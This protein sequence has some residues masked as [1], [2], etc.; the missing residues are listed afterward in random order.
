M[1][2][3]DKN[4]ELD[5]SF[6]YLLTSNLDFES[7]TSGSAQPQITVTNL[8]GTEFIIPEKKVLLKFSE[9]VEPLFKKRRI[10][11]SQIQSLT[12]T[13]DTLLPKLMNGQVRVKM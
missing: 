5:Y 3:E 10:N 11:N 8:Q 9:I 1:A 13:R 7:V 12:K 6:I 4:S 2:L